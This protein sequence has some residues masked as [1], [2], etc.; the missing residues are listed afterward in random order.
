MS[1]MNKAKISLAMLR[2]VSGPMGPSLS[3][4]DAAASNVSSRIDLFSPTA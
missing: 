2:A 3:I 1:A 4:H